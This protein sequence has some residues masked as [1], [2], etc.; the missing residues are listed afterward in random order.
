MNHLGF[1]IKTLRKSLKMTQADLCCKILNRSS[2]CKI[3]NNLII[4]SL[5]Q[6]EHIASKLNVTVSDLLQTSHISTLHINAKKSDVHIEHLFN[7]KKYL[8]I[9]DISMPSNFFYYF[10]KGMSYYKLGLKKD[11][12]KYLSKCEKFFNNM[13]NYNRFLNVE[14]LS[15][16]LNSLRK[17]TIDSFTSSSNMNYLKKI[18]NYLTVYNC[19]KCEIY[20][21]VINNIG[22]YHLHKENYEDAIDFLESFL[23]INKKLSYINV[24]ASIHLNLSIAKFAIKNYND[25]I[26]HIEKA[27]FFYNYAG[28]SFEACECYLNLFNYHIYNKDYNECSNIINYLHN[29]FHIPQ[30]KETFKILKLILLY[31][32]GDMTKLILYSKKVNFNALRNKSKYDYF[33]LIGRINFFLGKYR[34][35]EGYYNKCKKYLQS[36][37][38]YSDLSILYSDMYSIYGSKDYFQHYEKYKLLNKNRTFNSIHPDIASSNL[39][40]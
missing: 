27:I 4:P 35:V 8:D 15:I 29:E 19:K 14:K 10:Y 37:K 34:V 38:R 36:T 7:N 5:I 12:E 1:K 22:A 32:I 24:F 26:N 3:E 13:D 33:F 2:M 20:Y 23:K 28:E 25:A 9:I 6:L 30:I 11:A 40:L 31:N 39:V 21:I 17:L 16:S 18:L